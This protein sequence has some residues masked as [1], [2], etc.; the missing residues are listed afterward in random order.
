MQVGRRRA[1]VPRIAHQPECVTRLD[2]LS[3]A[4]QLGIEV[5]IVEVVIQSIPEPYLLTTTGRGLNA[6]HT[7]L[8]YRY[9]GRTPGRKD[10]NTVMTAPSSITLD[11]EKG[12]GTGD[13]VSCHWEYERCA[14]ADA[15]FVPAICQDFG[16]YAKKVDAGA[17][18]IPRYATGR[19]GTG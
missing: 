18:N 1:G 6:R 16:L 15:Y 19:V 11:T 14:R 7:A 8:A 2:V 9:H 4:Y 17:A 13:G 12:L 10:V 5:G 3:F